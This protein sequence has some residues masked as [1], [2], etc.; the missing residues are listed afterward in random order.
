M[1]FYFYRFKHFCLHLVTSLMAKWSN[2]ITKDLTLVPIT[3]CC[4][5]IS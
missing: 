5:Y 4:K 1:D 3:S 2:T